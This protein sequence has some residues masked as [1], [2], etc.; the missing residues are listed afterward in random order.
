[1]NKNFISGFLKGSAF[2]SLGTLS[3]VVFH[4]LSI[5]LMTRFVTREELGL[6]FLILAIVNGIKILGSLGLDLTLVK[7]LTSEEKDVQEDTFAAI[8]WV[9]LL[10]L[11]GFT[12]LVYVLGSSLLG[13]FDPGIVSYQLYLPILFTLMSF[14]EL[15]FYILQGLRKFSYY[16]GIQT[17]SGLF[18]FSLIA[19]VGLSNES[20]LLSDLIY[21]EIAMLVISTLILLWALPLRDLSPPRLVF[22]RSILKTILR[23]GFPLYINSVF[24]FISNNAAVFIVGIFL[25]PVS[26]AAYEVAAKIPQGFSRLFN[27][28]T[29]VYYPSLSS[30]FA[31]NDLVN[32]RALMNKSL[33]LLATLTFSFVLGGLLFSQEIVLLVFS[34]KYLEVQLTFVLLLLSTCMNLLAALMGFSLVS[35]GYPQYSTKVNII[36][37]SLELVLSILLI[38]AIGYIGAAVSYVIMTLISQSL[39]Y[40]Y[41]RSIDVHIDLSTYVRPFFFLI[42]I[43]GVYV[44]LDNESFILRVALFISYIALSIVFIPDCRQ[45]VVYL[46]KWAERSWLK[47]RFK[48][49]SHT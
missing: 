13:Y 12:I 35:A 1:M 30:L 20:L 25:S 17:A 14:R 47:I 5:S 22:K 38:P 18:K 19:V 40:Y 44:G 24:T 34:E 27:S 41:L 46:W 21:I 39:G 10:V 4:F 6:Y 3:T 16:A 32:A 33:I 37:M 45:S 48:N 8:I 31:D 9:R 49:E 23:F 26:I 15:F 28:F 36:S 29:T 42:L 2:T 11:I 7:F 43:S